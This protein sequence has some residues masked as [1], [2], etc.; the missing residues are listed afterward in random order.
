MHSSNGRAQ[1]LIRSHY[2]MLDGGALP[3]VDS[4]HKQNAPTLSQSYLSRAKTD[5]DAAAER[6]GERLAAVAN[7]RPRSPAVA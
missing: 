3:I 5:G 7:S 4:K 1:S 2:A 6:A